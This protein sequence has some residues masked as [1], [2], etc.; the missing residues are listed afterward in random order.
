M[1]FAAIGGVRGDFK[2]LELV[3]GELRDEGIQT[4]VNTGDSAVGGDQPDKAV[5]LLK[6]QGILSAQGDRDRLLTRFLRKHS[7]L[8]N[9]LSETDLQAFQHAYEHCG[10]AALEYLRTLPTTLSLTI[11]GIGIAVCHGTLTS[12][13]ERL[14]ADSPEDLFRRQRELTPAPIIVCGNNNEPFTHQVENTLFVSPGYLGTARDGLAHF[15]VVSTESDPW[16][17]DLRTLANDSR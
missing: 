2:S 17:V 6:E 15:A 4:I 8:K 9:R 10:S 14:T 7:S 13:A 16:Q 1:I 5:R 3:L 12:Q 11:D